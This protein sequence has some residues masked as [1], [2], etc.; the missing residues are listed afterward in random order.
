MVM[1][2][3]TIGLIVIFALGLF[4]G[5]LL[6]D[7]QQAKKMP[8]I[9]MLLPL[10]R[11]KTPI[12]EQKLRDLG[13]VDG[14]NIALERRYAEGNLNRLPDLAAEL[15]GL[16]VDILLTG[17][18]AATLA[19]KHATN[20]LPIVFA[21][22][23]DPLGRGLVTNLARPG[24]NITGVSAFFDGAALASKRMELLKEAVPSITRVAIIIGNTQAQSATQRKKR[25]EIRE[26]TSQALGLTY[27]FFRA[28]SVE[29]LETQVLPAIKADPHPFDALN[30]AGAVVIKYR[31]QLADFALKN[32]LPM[33][34][35]RTNISEAGGLAS[36]SV[37]FE[38]IAQRVAVLVS[39]VLH[40]A[41][42]GD[43]PV[44]QTNK[45][46]FVINMKT[47]KALG[48]TIP[49][50]VLYQATKIIR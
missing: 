26:R 13:Y 14:Q 10:S 1:R 42:P 49:P 40:G 45:Y 15:V 46:D 41:K 50:D 48:I 21:G 44:E 6:A 47:A 28:L 34:G 4:A 5:P 29:E 18:N 20:T 12:L 39:K 37:N 2:N 3:K 19:A 43:L 30:V 9:G 38:A 27:R 25:T 35:H 11:L 24:G 36:Y 33:M 31:R 17:G 22:A 16:P 32:R 23:A 8:R 7:A